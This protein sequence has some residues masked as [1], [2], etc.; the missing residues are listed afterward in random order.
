MAKFLALVALAASA[1]A[2]SE[3]F[4]GTEAPIGKFTYVSSIRID[5]TSPA[6][7][8]A[9][10]IAPKLLLTAA[11]CAYK[12]VHYASIGSHYT[13]G[14]KDGE[15]IKI[16]KK[17]VHPKYNGARGEFNIAIFELENESKFAPVALNWVEDAATAPGTMAWVRG[18]GATRP[19]GQNQSTVFLEAS[20]RIWSNNDCD[21]KFSFDILPS[22]VCAGGDG[23]SVTLFDTGAPLT[24]TR[25]GVEYVTGVVV[26]ESITFEEYEY[27]GVYMRT[28]AFRDFIESFLPVTPTTTKPAC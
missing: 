2:K 12:W 13:S 5:E 28:S 23:K 16:V 24:V 21:D 27:P 8:T 6:I 9:S 25:N 10:L 1:A 4:N 7:C 20:V 26:R 14:S 17:T 18:F 11:L 22:H 3:I 15:R 19:W